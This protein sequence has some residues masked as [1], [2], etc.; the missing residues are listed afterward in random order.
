M[1]AVLSCS[2]EYN[3]KNQACSTEHPYRRAA[4]IHSIL[5]YSYSPNIDTSNWTLQ[6]LYSGD[7]ITCIR[8]S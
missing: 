1:K 4:I 7:P 3:S 8:I 5:T 6:L 2:G